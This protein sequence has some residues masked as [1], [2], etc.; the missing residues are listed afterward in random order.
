M[1]LARPIDQDKIY[2]I[3]QHKTVAKSVW[4]DGLIKDQTLII[5]LKFQHL[6]ELIPSKNIMDIQAVTLLWS[7]TDKSK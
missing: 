3:L 1:T 5:F 7:T 6:S 4:Y 2:T